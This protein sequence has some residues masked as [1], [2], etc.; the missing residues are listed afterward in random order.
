MSQALQT[1][2]ESESTRLLETLKSDQR[3]PARKHN[4]QRNYLI[5]LLMLDAGLR[6]GEVV[7][8]RRLDLYQ[9]GRPVDAI[10]LSGDI[11]RK[12]ASRIVPLTERTQ[13]HIGL[14]NFLYWLND[15][16]PYTTFA[17]ARGGRT[18]ALTTRQVERI[19]KDAAIAALGKPVHP[20]ILRHTFATRLMRTTS[21]PIV[22]QLLG[23][24]KLSSTQIYLHPNSVDLKNAINTLEP[25]EPHPTSQ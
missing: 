21:T 4:S 20:H 6:V 18:R 10:H 12:G 13:Q 3:T 17:F 9:H 23:H 1:L 11:A 2:D 16:L 25:S 5:A 14:V 15:H 8:L 7:R 24:K 22:Q 19:I